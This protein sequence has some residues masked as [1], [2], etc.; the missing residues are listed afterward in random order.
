MGVLNI[1]SN[2][3]VKGTGFFADIA[4]PALAK[5]AKGLYGNAMNGRAVGRVGSRVSKAKDY[6]AAQTALGTQ[7]TR[8]NQRMESGNAKGASLKAL[9]AERDAID[10]ANTVLSK[11]RNSG[12]S[13]ADASKSLL[14]GENGLDSMRMGYEAKAGAN[15]G[16]LPGLLM[17]SAKG[18]GDWGVA[19]KRAAVGGTA[20]MGLAAGARYASGGGMTYNNQGQQDIAGIPFI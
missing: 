12:M 14:T 7:A 4:D 6:D 9:Q 10:K 20:F 2:A 18:N 15:L 11:S 17:D 1:M 19:A 5:A 8:V 16:D 13:Y 3:G